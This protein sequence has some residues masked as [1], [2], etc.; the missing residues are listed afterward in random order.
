MLNT[1]V[2]SDLHFGD[3]YSMLHDQG[4]PAV[5]DLLK[6]HAQGSLRRL[7]LCGDIFEMATPESMDVVRCHAHFFFNEARSRFHIGEIVWVPGNHDYVLFRRYFPQGPGTSWD[8]V[9]APQA[10]VDEFFGAGWSV[11]VRVAYPHLL[12]AERRAGQRTGRSWV[13]H[14]GHYLD[15]LML[16]RDWEHRFAAA[17]SALMGGRVLH[18]QEV[19]LDGSLSLA[20]LETAMR[21]VLESIWEYH[22]NLNDLQDECWELVRRFDG[23][24][25]CLRAEPDLQ[26]SGAQEGHLLPDGDVQKATMYLRAVRRDPAYRPPGGFGGPEAITLIYGHTH[27]GGERSAVIDGVPVQMLNLGGWLAGEVP[28]KHRRWAHT[29]LYLLNDDLEGRMLTTPFPAGWAQHCVDHGQTV[30]AIPGVDDAFVA[31]VE[32]APPAPGL[33]VEDL[34]KWQGD[35]PLGATKSQTDPFAG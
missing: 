34:L 24:G 35:R 30:F 15:D 17:F 18:P 9:P 1:A 7:V 5:L 13:L 8:G 2:L 27:Q 3:P 23:Y 22:P 16:G 11:P 28:T 20:A 4:V 29:H 6:V 31:A 12:L 14:H 10:L 32:A 19:P 25:A 21:P 26:V 33:S